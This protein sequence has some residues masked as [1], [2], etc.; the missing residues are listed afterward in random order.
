VKIVRK[1]GEILI[2]ICGHRSLA[3]REEIQNSVNQ[4]LE[5]IIRHFKADRLGFLSSLAEGADRLVWQAYQGPVP[6]RLIVFLPLSADEYAEDFNME[7]QREFK[8]LIGQ[9]DQVVE[10]SYSEARPEAYIQAGEAVLDYCDVLLALWDGEEACGRGG[11]ADVVTR[12]RQMGLPMAWIYALR[13][14]QK[15]AGFGGPAPGTLKLERFPE[16]TNI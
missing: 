6:A 15:P 11:T 12:A 10:I 16:S 1:P 9:A 4:A 13:V 8:Y 5:N 14:N 3:Y 7:S 2:A